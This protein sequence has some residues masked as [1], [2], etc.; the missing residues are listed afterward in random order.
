MYGADATLSADAKVGGEERRPRFARSALLLLRCCALL[1]PAPSA[2]HPNHTKTQQ[3]PKHK[4]RGAVLPR[5]RDRR[6]WGRHGDRRRPGKVRRTPLLR[7]FCGR[8]R[9]FCFLPLIAH[10]RAQWADETHTTLLPPH[11]N[12]PKR[13]SL[14]LG[15][16]WARAL[17]LVERG[18]VACYAGAA[19]G[20]RAFEVAGRAARHT[21]L[22]RRYCSCQ[23]HR[24]E[25]VS[26][27][28]AA[29]VS[30]FFAHAGKVWA[31]AMLIVVILSTF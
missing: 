31:V 2:R 7:L 13:L 30:R 10:A 1:V 14:L 24:Y 12:T 4:C 29:Y 26:R 3:T 21:V 23:A 5:H 20:R 18:A 9:F 8:V 19:T 11:P 27:G 22:P 25:V 28:E 17:Q 6:E 15:R 16:N